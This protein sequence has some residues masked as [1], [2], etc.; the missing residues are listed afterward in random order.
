MPVGAQLTSASKPVALTAFK[1]EG[2]S[3]SPPT[4]STVNFTLSGGTASGDATP[5][6]ATSWRLKPGRNYV[7]VCVYLSGP[8]MPLIPANPGSIP[9]ANVLVALNDT[10]PF[11]ALTGSACGFSNALEIGTVH[12]TGSNRSGQISGTIGIQINQSGLTLL[13][14]TY[15]G[16]LNI[17][18]E[19]I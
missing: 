8:L 10:P 2:L 7:H 11:T 12:I 9:A 17:I 16:T 1:G 18:A 19:A 6:W 13:P 5:S 4:V 15:S 14:D 3:I